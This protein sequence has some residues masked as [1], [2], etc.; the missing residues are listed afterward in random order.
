MR[1]LL[2]TTSTLVAAA[3]ISSYAVADVSVT[4]EFEW[5]YSQQAADQTSKD[6]DSFHTDNEVVISFSNKTDTGLTVGGKVELDV[7]T[8]NPAG[9]GGTIN[10]ESVLTISGGFGTFR[11][12]QEDPIDE[13]F[14]I[15][16]QDLIDE[17]G[18]G[19]MGSAS[20]G[21]T[22]NLGLAGDSN[23][24]AYLTP[25]MG[26]FQAGYSIADSGDNE[27][28]D[29]NAIGA[30]YSMPIGG[31]SITVKYNQ[32][33]LDGGTDTDTTNMGIQ[34]NMGAMTL[35]AS[36]GTKEIASNEDI[37]GNGFG[38]KYD[39]GGGM[40]I[41][42]AT[43]EVTDEQ[44]KDGAEE[45]KYTANIGEIVYTVAPG[46]KAKVTYTDYEYKNGGETKA[47]GDDSGQITNLT[48]SASF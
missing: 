2:L 8:T 35:I 10:D 24:I 15:D 48:I 39:M 18:N 16:E 4:A 11:L 21:N 6:G 42:A 31:G 7:D 32:A 45:E 13:T 26:G 46:L 29:T 14:G 38:I 22:S 40:T 27:T 47:A 44:D 19:L 28:T 37:E 30:S 23:K 41:A 43:V 17:E 1:K 20:L 3:S 33:T 34:L 9:G 12:G 36:S 5:M 25:K